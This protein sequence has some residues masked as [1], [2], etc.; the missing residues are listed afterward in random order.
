MFP[1]AARRLLPATAGE[2]RVLKH[3]QE[4]M[5]YGPFVPGR[6]LRNSLFF[7]VFALHVAAFGDVPTES[8]RGEKSCD[9]G[10]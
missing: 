1:L 5:P 8:S 10:K 4:R 6:L 7:S 9:A 2:T 3:F